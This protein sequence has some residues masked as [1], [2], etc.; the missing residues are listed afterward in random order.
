MIKS[1]E[2]IQSETRKGL[3]YMDEDPVGFMHRLFGIPY[4][5]FQ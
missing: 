3:N 4:L 2:E 5:R 1:F